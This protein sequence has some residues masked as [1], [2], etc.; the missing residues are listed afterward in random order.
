MLNMKKGIILGSISFS[1][2]I[3]LCLIIWKLDLFNPYSYQNNY[4]DSGGIS[5]S[6]EPD[7]L[8]SEKVMYKMENLYTYQGS[9]YETGVG[10]I[11]DFKVNGFYDNS[12][13]EIYNISSDCLNYCNGKT[14]IRLQD[15]PA[16]LM[17]TMVRITNYSDD[18]VDQPDYEGFYSLFV[19]YKEYYEYWLEPERYIG[20][21]GIKK[22]EL[23]DKMQEKADEQGIDW[24]EIWPDLEEVIV[25]ETD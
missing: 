18:S 12:I 10:K 20:I 5:H 11:Y 22:L 14:M 2:L 3:V 8:F 25:Y 16:G 6:C 24:Y 21:D 9:S 23:P 7:D 17:Y 15:G 1:I 13:S 4:S 19:G